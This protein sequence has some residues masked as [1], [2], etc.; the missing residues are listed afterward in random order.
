MLLPRFEYHAPADLEEACEMVGRFKE[1]AMPMA[2]GT[3]ILVGMKKGHISTENLISL[4][5][6][7][8]LKRT[9]LD[10]VTGR[11]K[12]GGCTTAAELARRGGPA[13]RFG[14][15]A[16]AA[17]SLGTPL[18][19]NM[20]TVGGNLVT[21]RPAADLSP[22]LMAYGAAVVLYSVGGVR[23]VPL[24]LFFIGPG[25]TAVRDDELLTE[26]VLD[27]PPPHSGCGYIKLC[28]RRTLEIGL[29]N[30]AAFL[31]LEGP[32]GP[33]RNAR[34]VLGSVAP[35]PMRARSA[36]RKVLG[37]RPSESLFMQAG[38]AAAKESRP[39]DDFRASAEFRREMVK[40]LTGRALE[41]AIQEAESTW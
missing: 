16:K 3:D 20:A 10:P 39:I 13:G 24:D 38:E 36:E 34:I 12:I 37:E 17:G 9:T 22:P 33:I 32:G 19:R 31:T 5:R 8:S 2:G 23:S 21:A 28:A 18:I 6:I 29:V 30:V 1:S 41:A 25:K 27:S 7:V 40:V 14:A 4:N 26:I 35:V 15:L 11:A